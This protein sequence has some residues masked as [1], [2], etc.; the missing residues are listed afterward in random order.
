MATLNYSLLWSDDGTNWNIPSGLPPAFHT[1]NNQGG[2]C[3]FAN[4]VD[5]GGTTRQLWVAEVTDLVGGHS[6]WAY[7]TDGDIW[8]ETRTAAPGGPDFVSLACIN[9]GSSVPVGSYGILIQ[10]V[11]GAWLGSNDAITW[12]T[13][14]TPTISVPAGSN[15]G[16]PQSQ[17]VAFGD[18]YWVVGND[19]LLHA[20]IQYSTNLGGAW[21]SAV[22]VAAGGV[23]GISGLGFDP[24]NGQFFV[25]AEGNGNTWDFRT[26]TSLPPTTWSTSLSLGA[27]GVSGI[28]SACFFTYSTDLGQLLYLGY[29]Q[30]NLTPTITKNQIISSNDDGATWTQQG[31]PISSP[32]LALVAGVWNH[33]LGK[34]L[35]F[36]SSTSP[37]W[38]YSAD[39]VTWTVLSDLTVL[40]TDFTFGSGPVGP[41]GLDAATGGAH[42]GRYVLSGRFTSSKTATGGWS[43]GMQDILGT[44]TGAGGWIAS[45]LP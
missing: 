2:T 29:E 9:D 37:V 41:K 4:F 18:G 24:N 12:T 31:E 26:S 32:E 33:T 35:V 27:V 19:S 14:A 11:S 43:V 34:W 17:W 7:S 25:F 23:G 42:T 21:S 3:Q 36:D 10:D 39:G 28:S 13:V 40:D 15:A 6:H 45:T 30:Q 1:I 5:P 20:Q 38:G 16:T 44:P 8:V 22:N